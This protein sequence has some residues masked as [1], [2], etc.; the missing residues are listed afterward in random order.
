MKQHFSLLNR[1][2]NERFIKLIESTLPEA[3]KNF[4]EFETPAFKEIE[5]KY[6][7]EKEIYDLAKGSF[8]AAKK[9]IDDDTQTLKFLKGMLTNTKP[10]NV[11]HTLRP[12]SH[13]DEV[14]KK[15]KRQFAQRI[16]WSELTK[17]V[18]AKANRFMT[19]DAIIDTIIVTDTAAADLATRRGRGYCKSNWQVS[20]L[21]YKKDR[22]TANG[23]VVYKEK[24]GLSDWMENGVPKAQYMV[25]FVHGFNSELQHAV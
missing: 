11:K 2:Q 5:A 21:D 22:K 16:S 8:E 3:M 24:L 10:E 25:S 15:E 7:R 13:L 20:V 4:E 17:Q 6:L 23:L 1:S 19:K 9:S 14:R 18:L 12:T